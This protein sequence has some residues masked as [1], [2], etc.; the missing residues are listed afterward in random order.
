MASFTCPQ[1]TKSALLL[2]SVHF[3]RPIHTQSSSAAVA[4]STPCILECPAVWA[5]PFHKSLP[6]SYPL[7][8]PNLPLFFLSN[9]LSVFPVVSRCPP[10]LHPATLSTAVLS[11]FLP[12]AVMR[13][14]VL[15]CACLCV[16]VHICV[17]L[18]VTGSC[19]K[20][21]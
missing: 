15:P 13:S 19:R 17:S 2:L 18:C 6:P 1:C 3:A 5:S 11:M 14:H 4:L 16:I 20:L 7:I 12:N 10:F 8:H 21:G 9:I